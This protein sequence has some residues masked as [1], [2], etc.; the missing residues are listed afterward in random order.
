[1]KK[2]NKKWRVNFTDGVGF[3]GTING[4]NADAAAFIL[5][6]VVIGNWFHLEML[7]LKPE[8]YWLKLGERVFRI[9]S[10]NGKTVITEDAEC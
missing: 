3:K 8:C 5:D 7:Q 10:A 2:L 6:E 4:N 1:M 9:H